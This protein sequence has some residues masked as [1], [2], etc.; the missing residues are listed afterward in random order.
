MT[1]KTSID[2]EHQFTVFT[3]GRICSQK[4]PKLFN[5]IAEAMPD[6]NF[7]WIGDGELRSELKSP[8]IHVTGWLEKDEAVKKSMQSDVFILT[9]LWEGL[10]IS[11]LEAMY[12]KKLCIVHIA[13]G[14]REIIHEGKNG[15]V[16]HSVED[17]VEKISVAR[18]S[19]VQALVDNAYA[20]VIEKYSA[21]VMA[22]NY[23]NLYQKKIKK[24]ARC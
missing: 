19:N 21:I 12:M 17:F 5:Q 22:R 13:V 9:S 15:F 8:N 10:P 2:P 20:D 1:A 4:N 7:L 24:N 14:N 6:I 16:C 23:N 3:L 11:I 18:N